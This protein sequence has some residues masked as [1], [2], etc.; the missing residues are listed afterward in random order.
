MLFSTVCFTG[1][2]GVDEANAR[3]AL[4]KHI[5]YAITNCGSTNFIVGGAVGIDTIAA[6]V[7]LSLREEFPHIRLFVAVPFR[8]FTA[9]WN[10]TQKARFASICRSCDGIHVVAD[11]YSRAAYQRRN[12]YM[13]DRADLVIAYYNGSAGGTR[14]CVSYAQSHHV[15]IVNCLS[16]LPCSY[17]VQLA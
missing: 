4:A 9:K 15:P 5:R 10:A 17:R 8:G 1:H 14:N 6:E 7:V 11:S 3:A 16:K 13:V 12:E 2:R